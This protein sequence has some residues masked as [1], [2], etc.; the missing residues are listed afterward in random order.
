VLAEQRRGLRKNFRGVAKAG[1]PV[2]FGIAA[3]P[4]PLALGILAGF[5]HSGR[6]GLFER[7][8]AAEVKQ[9]LFIAERFEGLFVSG[10]ALCEESLNFRD[11]TVF[12][13]SASSRLQA[14]IEGVAAGVQADLE[15]CVAFERPGFGGRGE[16]LASEQADLES[17]DR[18][19]EV[20]G[21]DARGGFGVE[22]GKDAMKARGAGL[23]A[24][25]EAG[26]EMPVAFGES[27][28]AAE[29]GAQIETAASHEDGETM[30]GGDLGDDI[31]GFARVFA[32]GVTFLRQ[33]HVEQMV[34]NLSPIGYGC[35]RGADV[36][37]PVEL[38]GVAVNDFASKALGQMEGQS[39]LTGAGGTD[40]G[41]K[42]RHRYTINGKPVGFAGE[43][44]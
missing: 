21:M 44:G 35:F 30:A 2:N 23:L 7:E 34:K 14:L 25:E 31:A 33:E 41:K 13:H 37:P 27:G 40:D 9:S 39:A 42:G 8:G 12:K 20:A 17:A 22:T 6:D 18:L 29:Q 28:K 32:G 24:G 1:E 43:G 11:Q 4:G 5:D 36:K 16:R 38:K 26:A 10:G 3:E 19:L 15:D